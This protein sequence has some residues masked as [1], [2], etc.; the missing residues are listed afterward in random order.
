MGAAY[1][2]LGRTFQPHQLA[3]ITLGS[4]VL[5]VMPKPWNPKPQHPSINA[6]S[7]AE[8]KFVKEYLSKHLKEEKH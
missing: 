5:L 4:V 2:V 6:S 7:P 1:T 3:L 8:E